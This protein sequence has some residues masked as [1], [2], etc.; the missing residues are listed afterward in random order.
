[1]ARPLD[2][3]ESAAV[4]AARTRLPWS[5]NESAGLVERMTPISPRDRRGRS[6]RVEIRDGIEFQVAT[7]GGMVLRR[8]IQRH[9]EVL[10]AG[11]WRLPDGSL[12]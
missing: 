8:R 6:H 12:P 3:Q 4:T 5:T 7:E 11:A 9:G 1:M 10:L 2:Q